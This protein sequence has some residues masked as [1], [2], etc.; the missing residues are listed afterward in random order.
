M[1]NEDQNLIYTHH[2][3]VLKY[4]TPL[5]EIMNESLSIH[6]HPYDKLSNWNNLK[7]SDL[8]IKPRGKIN[9]QI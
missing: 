9:K 4:Q 6:R 7:H 5:W 2:P 8:E 3:L 1:Y